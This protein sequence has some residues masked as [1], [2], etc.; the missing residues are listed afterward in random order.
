MSMGDV[1][2]RAGFVGWRPLVVV[3]K[4]RRSAHRSVAQLGTDVRRW[5][6]EWKT[7]SGRSGR[8]LGR[9]KTKP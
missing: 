4:L 6:N 1:V 3:G 2:R 7:Y 9:V 8:P 5:I